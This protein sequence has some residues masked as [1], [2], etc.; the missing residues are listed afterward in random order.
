MLSCFSNPFPQKFAEG[1]MATQKLSRIPLP[2][3]WPLHVKSA[4]LHIISLAHFSITHARGW[5]ANSV[6]ERV[7]TAAENDRLHQGCLSWVEL[8]GMGWSGVGAVTI[9][10]TISRFWARPGRAYPR[11]L[12]ILKC[13]GWDSNPHG[14]KAPRI[15]SP[16]GGFCNYLRNKQK[17][18]A[19]SGNC[20]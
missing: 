18:G 2:K 14:P 9:L 8:A 13:P 4:V 17:F 10:V 20:C 1:T 7:R 11:N 16:G 6:S 5:A 3:S 19:S 12:L 15:L